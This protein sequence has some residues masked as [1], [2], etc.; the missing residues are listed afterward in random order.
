MQNQIFPRLLQTLDI[1]RARRKT[2]TF[3]V[4]EGVDQRQW[5]PLLFTLS[6]HAGVVSVD[7]K[8]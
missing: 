1:P 2:V 5:S 7:G 8:R 3:Q 4:R 6:S